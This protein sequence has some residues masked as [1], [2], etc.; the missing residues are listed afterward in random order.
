MNSL[1]TGFILEP[2]SMPPGSFFGAGRKSVLPAFALGWPANYPDAIEHI[3]AFGDARLGPGPGIAVRF[4]YSNT[5]VQELIDLSYSELNPDKRKEL[6]SDAAK[7]ILEDYT[8]IF[9]DQPLGYFTVRENI[10]G[11]EMPIN[12]VK[13]NPTATFIDLYNLYRE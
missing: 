3:N 2:T 10:F 4:Q 9:I 5:D 13:H 12:I 8:Y 1:D 6:L 11:L 7:L